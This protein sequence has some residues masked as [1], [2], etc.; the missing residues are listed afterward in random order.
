V[1]DGVK[2]GVLNDPRQC[3]FDPSTLLC[4][5]KESDACLTAPQVASLKAIYAGVRDSAG[6]LIF[7]GA[8]PGAEEGRG[9]WAT[10]IT[11]SEEGKSSG[12]FFVTGYFADMVYSDPNWDFRTANIDDALKQAYAKTGDALDAMN[13]DLKPF[14]AH[15]KLI[16]YHGWNDPGISPL[17]TVDYYGKVVNTVGS[18]KVDQSLRLY[19]VPGMQHCGGGPGA[20]SFGQ[21][22]AA[23]RS[24]PQHDI[25]SAL[26]AWVEKGDAPTTIVATKYKETDPAKD[27]H[28][29]AEMTRPLCPYPKTAQYKG[30]GDRN[31]AKSFVCAPEGN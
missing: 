30:S 19:M 23:P 29:H 15:G 1:Q 11:G 6:Q 18:E 10:W 31:S 21:D 25:F 8:L 4:K 20:T 24:D 3:S 28:P 14:L 22:E 16:L 7:P 26:I 17:N 12:T 27:I 13:P 5:G 9:G 2:D